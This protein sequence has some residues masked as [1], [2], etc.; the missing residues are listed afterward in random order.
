MIMK[1]GL[2]KWKTNVEPSQLL[3][4]D[5][6]QTHVH[7]LLVVGCV[8]CPPLISDEDLKAYSWFY[9]LTQLATK[10][11]NANRCKNVISRIG[12]EK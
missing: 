5:N 11:Y 8:W 10:I 6:E 9:R 3:I 1:K 7:A 4:I 2:D 12:Y